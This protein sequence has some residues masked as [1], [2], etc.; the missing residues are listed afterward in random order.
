MTVRNDNVD[1]RVRGG[2]WI[3]VEL[4]AD[5]VKVGGGAAVSFEIYDGGWRGGHRIAR[6]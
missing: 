5:L 2:D 4:M 1:G 6:G 3:V